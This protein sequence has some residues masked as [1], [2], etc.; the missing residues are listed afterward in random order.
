MSNKFKIRNVMTI[1]FAHMVHDTYAAFLAPI[2]P[3]LVL[4]G[5]FIFMSGPV[6]LAFIHETNV[7]NGS[8]V[9]G[10][11]MTS[12]IFMTSCMTL[13]IG[14]FSDC[15]GLEMTYEFAPYIGVAAIPFTFLLIRKD[16]N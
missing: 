4:S 15:F 9:N 12:N 5:F 1:S 13:L 2:L 6:I 16:L 3:L 14:W 10:L 11:Y 8:F 7:S